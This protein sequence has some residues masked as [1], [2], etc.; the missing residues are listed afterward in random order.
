[1][2]GYTVDLED[3]HVT[4]LADLVRVQ[5]FHLACAL[6]EVVAQG[7]AVAPAVAWRCA[8]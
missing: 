8:L 4:D 3:A 6:I 5:Q 7:N 2:N 1:M